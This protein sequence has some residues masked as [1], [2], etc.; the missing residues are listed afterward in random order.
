M[1]V[2]ANEVNVNSITFGLALMIGLCIGYVSDK[3][4]EKLY[5]AIGKIL[6]NK[7]KK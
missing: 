4:L 7:S 1:K 6:R 2:L 3:N 5:K